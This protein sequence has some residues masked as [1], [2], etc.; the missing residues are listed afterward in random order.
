MHVIG[1]V[2]AAYQ[3]GAADVGEKAFADGAEQAM[4]EGEQRTLARLGPVADCFNAAQALVEAQE[5]GATSACA[6]A[7]QAIC[8]AVKKYKA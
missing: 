6:E 4:R 1:F 3:K 8:D 5:A 2:E 7:I